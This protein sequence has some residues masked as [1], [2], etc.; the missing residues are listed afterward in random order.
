MR[1]NFLLGFI[2]ASLFILTNFSPTMAQ[3]NGSLQGRWIFTLNTPF[4]TI[5]L[6]VVYKKGGK[7]MVTTPG[8]ALPLI[9]RESSSS[10]SFSLGVEVTKTISPTGMGFTF[11]LRGDKTN[12]NNVSGKLFLVTETTDPSSPIGIGVGNGTFTGVRQ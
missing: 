11:V 12:A 8:G 7:G 9:Y 4:G 3:S 2:F 6:P 1:K 10:S 5:P